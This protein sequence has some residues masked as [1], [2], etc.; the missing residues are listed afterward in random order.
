MAFEFPCDVTNS[1][2]KT[3]KDGDYKYKATVV[4]IETFRL[5]PSICHLVNTQVKVKLHGVEFFAYLINVNCKIKKIK[6]VPF[7]QYVL[8]LE[9]E[10][11]NDDV[12]R[13][14]NKSVD[15]VIEE[16]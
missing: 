16:E 4:T 11:I 2:V 14:V 15:A 12:A 3:K 9:F 6:K 10:G 13:L 8:K 5:D 7:T 1:N